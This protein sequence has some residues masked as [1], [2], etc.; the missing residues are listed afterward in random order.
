[1]LNQAYENEAYYAPVAHPHLKWTQGRGERACQYLKQLD[2]DIYCLQEVNQS[3][4]AQIRV[5]LG[6]DQYDMCWHP[7]TEPGAKNQDGLAVL[8]RVTRLQ[9]FASFAWYYPS[10]KHIVMACGFSDRV[11]ADK[12]FWCVD[13]HVNWETREEDLAHLQRQINERTQFVNLPLPLVVMGDFNAERSENWYRA[14]G[15]NGLVDPMAALAIP[16]TYNSGKLA[17]LIDF[18]LLHNWDPAAA[19]KRIWVGLGPAQRFDY[20]ALP[21]S[22]VPSD[23]LPLSMLITL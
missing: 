18:M 9:L 22:D 8:Y 2:S 20:E 17:K 4:A 7:R 19:V 6:T 16:Y 5:S 11:E 23:H 14:L 15:Q 3:M 12:K 13:T 1:V 10:R 21:S